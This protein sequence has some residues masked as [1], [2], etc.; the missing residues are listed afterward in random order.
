MYN[1]A[2]FHDPNDSRYDVGDNRGRL[3]TSCTPEF[4]DFFVFDLSSVTETIV[5][6]KLA[7]LLPNSIA[8]GYFSSDPSEN[9]ELHDVTTPISTLVDGTSGLAAWN[10]LGSGVVYGSRTMTPADTMPFDDTIVE[11]DLNDS[12][13]AA[14][15]SSHGLFAI[16]GS[17][18]TLDTVANMELVF[19]A[20]GLVSDTSQLRL[21]LVP[22]PFTLL[23]LGIGAIS[24][25][26]RRKAK[27]HG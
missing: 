22:E 3:C 9:Y 7:L 23:L 10:D 19:W 1:A 2:G 27:S 11:I 4:R 5:S 6:A 12:A 13:I 21:T 16:G 8:R 20:T 18:T 26:G 14:L 25:L 24:L 17:L 15:N